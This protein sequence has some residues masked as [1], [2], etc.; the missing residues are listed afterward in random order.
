MRLR[1]AAGLGAA[2]LALAVIALTA[3]IGGDAPE[4]E[5]AG[6][7]V[8]TVQ[9]EL[10]SGR[11]VFARMGCGSCHTLAAAGSRGLI[12]PDLDERL[13][14]HTRKSLVARITAPPSAGG[15]DFGVMPRNFGRRMSA[16][17][18]NALVDFLMAAREG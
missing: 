6:R 16:A 12:G 5:P 3:G 9:G 15:Q 8:T 1:L 13:P 2:A 17:E 18:L 11:A 7:P 4:T 10:D 14:A